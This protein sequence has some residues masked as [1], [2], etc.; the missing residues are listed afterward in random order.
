[1]NCSTESPASAMMRR[2]VPVRTCLRSGITEGVRFIAAQNH[3]AAG[4]AAENEAGAFE[5][6]FY[7]TAGKISG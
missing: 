4:L 2:S 6:C 7:F 1:M 3:M 5:R